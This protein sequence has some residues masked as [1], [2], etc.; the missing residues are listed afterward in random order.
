LSATKI[1]NI[2]VMKKLENTVSVAEP[3]KPKG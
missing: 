2:A 1:S 3:Q